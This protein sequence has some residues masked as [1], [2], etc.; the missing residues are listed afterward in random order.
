[1]TQSGAYNFEITIP[2]KN[3]NWKPNK[4]FLISTS[5]VIGKSQVGNWKGNVTEATFI[6]Y[7]KDI[8]NER[9]RRAARR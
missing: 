5:P 8:D 2:S 3:L 1:V 4:T 9:E 7:T 6:A